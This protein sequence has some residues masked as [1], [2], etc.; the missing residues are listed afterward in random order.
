MSHV[1]DYAASYIPKYW[2]INMPAVLLIFQRKKLIT[3]GTVLFASVNYCNSFG[4]LKMFTSEVTV[5]VPVKYI[6]HV[7]YWV[8]FKPSE[9]GFKF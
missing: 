1:A 9:R 8:I 5:V 2:P 4:I 6:Q 7:I 3:Q